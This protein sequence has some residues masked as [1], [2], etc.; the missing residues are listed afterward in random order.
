MRAKFD[1]SLLR[2]R[3][4]NKGFTLQTLAKRINM[5]VCTLCG[6]L[7]GNYDFKSTEIVQIADVLEIQTEDIPKYFFAVESKIS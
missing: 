2:R 6:K 1:Y 3:M 4:K 7:L 5:S